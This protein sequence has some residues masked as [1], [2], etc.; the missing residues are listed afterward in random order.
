[1]DFFSS[2]DVEEENLELMELESKKTPVFL[3]K[4]N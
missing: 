2:T 1:M 3:M 4:R